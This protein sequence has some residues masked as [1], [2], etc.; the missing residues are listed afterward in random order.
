MSVNEII[1]QTST[2]RTFVIKA[3]RKLEKAEFI[4]TIRNQ[5]HKQKK[6]KQLSTLGHTLA[7]LTFN[8]EN[9]N[10][11]HFE[12]NK[13]IDEYKELDKKIK[14]IKEKNKPLTTIRKTTIK[15]SIFRELVPIDRSSQRFLKEKLKEKGWTATEISYYEGCKEGLYYTDIY[16]HE[17][18]IKILLQKFLSILDNFDLNVGAREIINRIIIE[19]FQ[20][21]LSNIVTN[22]RTLYPEYLRNHTNNTNDY[23]QYY[24]SF[25]YEPLDYIDKLRFPF[26][27]PVMEIVKKMMSAYLN[28]LEPSKRNIIQILRDTRK[29]FEN[30]SIYEI[31]EGDINKE[32][33][34]MSS[35]CLIEV[36]K[37]YVFSN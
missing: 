8:I 30:S 27:S 37:K 24:P 35:R 22:I 29:N 3:L 10:S 15:K 21:Q 13:V 20:I 9:F 14:D 5:S 11:G 2:D 1:E 25:K 32:D 17:G 31:N 7:Q 18:I 33:I 12:I 6:V 16:L 26:Q 4:D 19:K 36:F 34:M 28:L 23:S